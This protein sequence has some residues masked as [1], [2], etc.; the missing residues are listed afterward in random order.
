MQAPGRIDPMVYV[1]TEIFTEACLR[2]G[3]VLSIPKARRIVWNFLAAKAGDQGKAFVPG[4]AYESFSNSQMRRTIT[5]SVITCWHAGFL[6]LG[7][8]IRTRPNT[9]LSL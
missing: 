8:E 5:D 4:Q 1:F 6:I 3:A 2:G 7:F 9:E